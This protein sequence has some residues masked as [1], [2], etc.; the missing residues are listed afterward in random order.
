MQLMQQ[1]KAQVT[2]EVYYFDPH[3]MVTVRNITFN[4]DTTRA[5]KE[6]T[7]MVEVYDWIGSL[8]T[9]QNILT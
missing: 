1:R 4:Y 8:S 3:V 9:N 6:G 2:E 7:D 5:F